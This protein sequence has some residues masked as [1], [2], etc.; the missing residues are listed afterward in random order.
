MSILIGKYEFEAPT[1]HADIPEQ[2]GLYAVIAEQNQDLFLV[3]VHDTNN[4]HATL[5]SRVLKRNDRSIVYLVSGDKAERTE[6]LNQLL[7]EF[8]FDHEECSQGGGN[9]RTETNAGIAV[10]L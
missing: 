9:K 5:V 10:S 3:E 4:L 1:A 2:P 6:A 7:C 8:E